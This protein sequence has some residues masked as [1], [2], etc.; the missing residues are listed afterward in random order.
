[1]S[2]DL[3][4]AEETESEEPTYDLNEL[5]ERVVKEIAPD[6]FE[7]AAI[8]TAWHL[9][10]EVVDEDGDLRLGEVARDG[11][12][13]WRSQGMLSAVITQMRAEAMESDLAYY[14]DD[15]EE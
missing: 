8:P 3:E 15:D 7:G 5:L 13:W 1:M 4:P 9:V 6:L 11:Q 10:M 12:P 2:D 14:E